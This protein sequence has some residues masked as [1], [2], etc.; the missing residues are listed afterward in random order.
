MCGW[1]N[2]CF[3]KY[4]YNFHDPATLLGHCSGLCS[5]SFVAVS[6]AVRR[7]KRKDSWER[8]VSRQ[9]NNSTQTGCQQHGLGKTKQKL[10][11]QTTHM[12]YYYI[13]KNRDKLH[14][15]I[16]VYKNKIRVKLNISPQK[17]TCLLHKGVG[18]KDFFKS[19][20]LTISNS[21]INAI[22]SIN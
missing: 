16:Q 1:L 5:D 18:D 12:N 15:C 21:T 7:Q 11:A 6:Q 19:S 14:F 17:T 13:N 2:V 9:L 22:H 20:T 8:N 4:I 10:F 3:S